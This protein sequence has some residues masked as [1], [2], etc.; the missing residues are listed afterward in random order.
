MVV[1]AF[2]NAKSHKASTII[3]TGLDCRWHHPADMEA[4]RKHS[5]RVEPGN[6]PRQIVASKSWGSCMAKMQCMSI[7]VISPSMV[8]RPWMSLFYAFLSENKMGF[9]DFGLAIV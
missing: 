8:I 1:E 9:V 7:F 3:G 5:L 2:Y 4:A 6:K